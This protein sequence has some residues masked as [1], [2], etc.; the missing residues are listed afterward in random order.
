MDSVLNSTIQWRLQLM[1]LINSKFIILFSFIISY[2]NSFIQ[3]RPC[4]DI[5]V[6]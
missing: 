3:D 4:F 2:L 6:F 1:N 5:I